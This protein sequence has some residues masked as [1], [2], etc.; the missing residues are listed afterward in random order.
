MSRVLILNP[1]LNIYII[2]I[3]SNSFPE[4]LWKL[5]SLR[6]LETLGNLAKLENHLAD[7]RTSRRN[8]NIFPRQLRKSVTRW[9][10]RQ[11]KKGHFSFS[12][13]PPLWKSYH[14][15]VWCLKI[16]LS[17]FYQLKIT[18]FICLKSEK[19]LKLWRLD[20]RIEFQ[21]FNRKFVNFSQF[22]K[23]L[24]YKK[25]VNLTAKKN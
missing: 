9:E 7:F 14:E 18:I 8:V 12:T 22:F 1:K 4:F 10:V 15:K 23:T 20:P 11:R 25:S 16:K 24:S 2:C 21:V 13:P 19:I 17:F 3:Q 6:G 5:M